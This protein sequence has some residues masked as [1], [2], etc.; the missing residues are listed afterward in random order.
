MA[1]MRIGIA[2]IAEDS[3]TLIIA[4]RYG[5][6]YISKYRAVG[7]IIPSLSAGESNTWDHHLRVTKTDTEL[8]G[9]CDS[10]SAL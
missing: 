6:G 10:D 4:R 1:S 2:A 3:P 7:G 5:R 9:I 8:F